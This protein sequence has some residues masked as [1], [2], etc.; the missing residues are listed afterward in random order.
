[1]LSNE[2]FN[3]LFLRTP[4]FRINA[5]L[6]ILLLNDFHNIFTAH[7]Q[8]ILLK[9][10]ERNIPFVVEV[11]LYRIVAAQ[12]L[13]P[14]TLAHID[15]RA[16]FAF[17]DKLFGLYRRPNQ[18]ASFLGL[19][20][21][22]WLVLNGNFVHLEVIIHLQDQLAIGAFNFYILFLHLPLILAK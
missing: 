21:L 5:L 11:Y 1:M 12:L 4:V 17:F 3:V 2:G 16:P 20:L 18:L 22:V 19:V 13:N 9:P 7:L 6:Y 10:L 15:Y 14:C 8:K